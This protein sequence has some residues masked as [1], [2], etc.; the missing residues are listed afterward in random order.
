MHLLYV[1]TSGN[2]TYNPNDDKVIKAVL[3]LS[4]QSNEVSDKI[5][6]SVNN[7]QK[8]FYK[9]DK[10]SADGRNV[11]TASDGQIPISEFNRYLYKMSID[12]SS[13][14]NL[15]ISL[16]TGIRNSKN[17]II[18]LDTSVPMSFKRA[19]TVVSLGRL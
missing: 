12:G 16:D 11:V 4:K 2:E 9:V 19:N 17:K 15:T 3:F 5:L 14:D 1:L 13:L 8:Y 7:E 18:T 10:I 6:V